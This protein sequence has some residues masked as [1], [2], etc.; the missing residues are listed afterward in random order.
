MLFSMNV[1]F[2]CFV[3]IFAIVSSCLNHQKTFE[4]LW[5]QTSTVWTPGN[6]V[7]W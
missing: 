3:L 5:V 1:S 2:R 6:R 7:I 4:Y